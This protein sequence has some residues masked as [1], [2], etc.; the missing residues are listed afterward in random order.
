VA[1]SSFEFPNLKS[2]PMDTPEDCKESA[3][4]AFRRA[5]EAT[6]PEARS[7]FGALA[8]QW[9]KLADA[10]EVAQGQKTSR[11]SSRREDA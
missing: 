6:T 11:S 1:R 7:E 10:M 2:E 8:A 5:T 3:R 9:L 4:D